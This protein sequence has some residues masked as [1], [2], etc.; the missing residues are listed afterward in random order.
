MP[1]PTVR[2]YAGGMPADDTASPAARRAA[3]GHGLAT[4]AAD[5]TVLDTWYPAPALG[6]PPDATRCDRPIELRAAR[7]APTT[8][9]PSPSRP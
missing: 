6:V 4:V 3:W 2:R 8:A 1:V 7:R 9:A 5:G